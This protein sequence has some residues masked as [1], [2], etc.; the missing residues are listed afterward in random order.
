MFCEDM[1]I[2]RINLKDVEKYLLTVSFTLFFWGEVAAQDIL[3][4][5]DGEVKNVYD[6]EMNGES[7]F[8]R[9]EK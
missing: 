6:V 8:Y 5:T 4:T 7:V 3:V 1:N 2:K 9:M